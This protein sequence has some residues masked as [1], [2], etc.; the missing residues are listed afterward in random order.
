MTD[1]ADWWRSNETIP[2]VFK[3]IETVLPRVMMGMFQDPDWFTVEAKTGR[4][5]QYEHLAQT[6]LRT[7]IDEMELF[8]KLYEAEKYCSIMGHVWGKVIW[9][10]E[11]SDRQILTEDSFVDEETGE[12]TVG[13]SAQVTTEEDFNG[14]D[15]EWRPLDRIFP[16]PTRS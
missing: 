14:P 12:E 3:I 5:Q 13:V 16:D 10:E 2:T 1:P 6:L 11:Y 4:N 9:R 15:F 8:P 7:S